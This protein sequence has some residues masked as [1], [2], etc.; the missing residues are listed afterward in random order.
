M[1]PTSYV[2]VKFPPKAQNKYNII[3]NVNPGDKRAQRGTK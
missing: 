2:I 1:R 3:I